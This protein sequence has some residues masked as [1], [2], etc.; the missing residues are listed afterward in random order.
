[1]APKTRNA[2]EFRV[3]GR[4]E[5]ERES[6]SAGHNA[7]S[8]KRPANPTDSPEEDHQPKRRKTS[9]SQA[10]FIEESD[11]D[12]DGEFQDSGND[13][14]DNASDFESAEQSNHRPNGSN[15][16]NQT[17]RR[18]NNRV[19]L[20]ILPYDWMILDLR[21]NK[22]LSHEKILL[23]LQK[24]YPDAKISGQTRRNVQMRHDKL[25][26]ILQEDTPRIPPEWQ[27]K[28]ARHFAPGG[29]AAGTG[30][31]RPRHHGTRRGRR[32]RP[33]RVFEEPEP[34]YDGEKSEHDFFSQ[35]FAENYPPS[36]H[37]SDRDASGEEEDIAAITGTAAANAASQK[38]Q[39][40]LGLGQVVGPPINWAN[41]F[42]QEPEDFR[43][44][45][46]M[47]KSDWPTDSWQRLNAVPYDMRNVTSANEWAL[48][49]VEKQ[50]MLFRHSVAPP[51]PER[52]ILPHGMH[53][54][55]VNNGRNWWT[56][57]VA[58]EPVV[59]ENTIWEIQRATIDIADIPRDQLQ[60]V[61]SRTPANGGSFGFWRHL[62]DA[63]EFAGVSLWGDKIDVA[64]RQRVGGMTLEE[65]A[66]MTG[67]R[68]Q[69]IQDANNEKRPFQMFVILDDDSARVWWVRPW[70]LM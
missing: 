48:F 69:S 28:L 31:A 56:V 42:N 35:T 70:P 65:I 64:N 15:R 66:W 20:Q 37:S 1:M 22:G 24:H 14:S 5:Q 11:N 57:E 45:V 46:K 33:T 34:S 60:E 61:L 51:K 50:K 49:I 12:S 2:E 25:V 27:S 8:L 63:N 7:G 39:N 3:P 4:R 59:P 58:R 62:E 30:P 41:M 6:R 44:F 13:A 47:G 17:S 18:R 10:H 38:L 36:I 52:T 19:G 40:L 29:A 43:Y 68:E 21:Y 16:A 53:S 9:G 55:H 23:A 67:Q 54:Y 26:I 32:A